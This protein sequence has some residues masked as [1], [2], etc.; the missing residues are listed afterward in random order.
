MIDLNSFLKS[1][2]IGWIRRLINKPSSPWA[3]L[4]LDDLPTDIVLSNI[5]DTFFDSL[6]RK[7]KNKFQGT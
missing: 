4:L 7:T 5:G 3:C 6:A 2:K 1:L